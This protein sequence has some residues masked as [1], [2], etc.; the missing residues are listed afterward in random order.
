MAFPCPF[1]SRTALRVQPGIVRHWPP[2]VKHKPPPALGHMPR[3]KLRMLPQSET[4]KRTIARPCPARAQG[5]SPNGCRYPVV[6]AV[7]QFAGA[8][9]RWQAWQA[10]QGGQGPAVKSRLA[11]AKGSRPRFVGLDDPASVRA[12][13]LRLAAAGR[14][15]GVCQRPSPRHHGNRWYTGTFAS[16]PVIGQ[17]QLLRRRPSTVRQSPLRG[18]S[19][20]STGRVGP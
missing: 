1:L 2:E 8:A 16:L 7:R 17:P 3:G 18:S 19:S 9:G 15:L 12:G 14:V 11:A 4:P 10:W 13:L 6:E 5:L 20:G